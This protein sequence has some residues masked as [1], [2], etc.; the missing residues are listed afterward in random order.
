MSKISFLTKPLALFWSVLHRWN[1]K[2][3]DQREPCLRRRVTIKRLW[4][5]VKLCLERFVDVLLGHLLWL[6]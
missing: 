2:R 3:L 4:L 6:V 1:V 5:C